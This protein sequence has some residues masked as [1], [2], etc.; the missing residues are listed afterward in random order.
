MRPLAGQAIKRFQSRHGLTETGSV[1]PKTLAALNVP[2]KNAAP[3]SCA[4]RSI[5]S[6]S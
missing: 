3:N 4:P 5:A 6:A 2:V 1:G